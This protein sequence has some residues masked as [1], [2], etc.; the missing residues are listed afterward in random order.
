MVFQAENPTNS[1]SPTGVERSLLLLVRKRCLSAASGEDKAEK[2]GEQ[3]QWRKLYAEDV[4]KLL[5]IIQFMDEERHLLYSWCIHVVR[6][7]YCDFDEAMCERGRRKYDRWL[8]AA[9]ASGQIIRY[10]DTPRE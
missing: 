4:S 1:Q 5:K 6:C 2:D 3:I 7:P 10:A 9:Q 8:A